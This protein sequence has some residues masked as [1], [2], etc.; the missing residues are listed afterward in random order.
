MKTIKL[1]EK[2]IG[3]VL[4]RL[5]RF[6]NNHKYGYLTFHNFDCG[7]KN[8]KPYAGIQKDITVDILEI[9]YDEFNNNKPYIR[10]NFQ[11]SVSGTVF[12]LGTR[13]IFKG[14]EIVTQQKWHSYFKE[15]YIY[16]V[17][18]LCKLSDND[19]IK[20]RER[21]MFEEDMANEYWNSIDY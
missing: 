11:K 20:I 8:I 5:K 3:M 21:R 1:T 16:S 10:V 7:Y 6:F 13:F 12:Y 15:N 9:D 19:K 2:N 14:N 18:R 4:G 17:Y